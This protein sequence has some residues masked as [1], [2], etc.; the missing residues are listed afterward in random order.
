MSDYQVGHLVVRTRDAR[1]VALYR[2]RL[3]VRARRHSRTSSLPGA[4]EAIVN[5]MTLAGDLNFGFSKL[6]SESTLTCELG[7]EELEETEDGDLIERGSWILSGRLGLIDGV[8]TFDVGDFRRLETLGKPY[9]GPRILSIRPRRVLPAG[10]TG[11]L[12]PIQVVTEDQRPQESIEVVRQAIAYV[13]HVQAYEEKRAIEAR[14]AYTLINQSWRC[15]NCNSDNDAQSD[16][17]YKC[18][19]PQGSSPYTSARVKLASVSARIRRSDFVALRTETEEIRGITVDGVKHGIASLRFRRGRRLPAAGEIGPVAAT[20]LFDAQRQEL[21]AI[22]D[23]H[24]PALRR[25]IQDPAAV[26]EPTPAAID[27]ES[28]SGPTPN[29]VQRTA[30]QRICGMTVGQLYLVQGPPGTGKT[31]AIVE[32]VGHLTAGTAKILFSSHSNDAVDS[33]QAR[34]RRIAGVRQIRLADP[35]RVGDDVLDLVK[36]ERDITGF[37]VVAGTTARLTIDSRVIDEEFDWLILDEANKVRISEALALMARAHRWVL[38]G[39]PQQLG[40]VSDDASTAFG[41]D[42][43]AAALVRDVSLYEWLWSRVPSGCRTMFRRQYRMASGVGSIVSQVFYGGQLE[44]DGP[45][46][47]LQLPWPLNRHVVWVDTG[48]QVE[49]RTASGSRANAF[50]VALCA[51]LCRLIAK[52]SRATSTAV[53][54]MYAQQ[55]EQLEKRLPSILDS[56][57]IASVDSFEGREADVVILSLVRSNEAARIGFLADAKR[58]NVAVSRAQRLLVVVGDRTTVTAA[59]KQIF[60]AIA[61]QVTGMES[62]GFSRIVKPGAIVTACTNAG[63]SSETLRLLT[64]KRSPKHSRTSAG[65]PKQSLTR[66]K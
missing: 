57:D 64:G 50:E 35:A 59:S 55:V 25:L 41:A 61:A 46:N 62:T 15:T 30:I 9:V 33:G 52:S 58:I 37:N 48:L 65:A 8:L 26:G 54:A 32:A 49:T 29:E 1:L 14:S 24:R 47:S 10:T 18:H 36:Q 6:P 63:V 34:L 4:I 19:E 13:D 38:I 28:G 7:L 31:T 20:Q 53:I 43:D 22:T 5:L 17:C 60:G 45:T 3:Q 42:T 44:L 66:R 39:D 21:F 2:G 16:A 40:P 56:V 51:D 27:L 23:G 11:Q 12:Q